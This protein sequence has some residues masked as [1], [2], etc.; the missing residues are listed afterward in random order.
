[1]SSLFDDLKE[2][3]K[4]WTTVAVEKAEEV[5]K[6]AVAKTEE[7]TRISK[8]KLEVHQHERDLAKLYEQLGRFVCDHAKEDNMVNFT[9]NSEF[10]DLVQKVD[11]LQSLIDGKKEDI[12]RVKDEYKLDDSDIATVDDVVEEKVENSPTSEIKDEHS[13]DE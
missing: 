7:V 5:G 3:V 2:T 6:I 11:Q 4:E 1:M 12:E 10:F 13:S 8:I 9:G